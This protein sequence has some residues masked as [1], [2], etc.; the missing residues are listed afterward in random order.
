M[1]DNTNL[2][3]IEK[4]NTTE[5]MSFR[6]PG[7][8]LAEAKRAAV[9]LRNVITQKEKP[10]IFNNEQYLEYEDWQLLGQFCGGIKAKVTWTR[11]LDMGGGVKGFEA[12]ADAVDQDGNILSSA[13][14]MCLNDEDNWST[15]S[16]FEY[17][18]IAEAEAKGLPI[19]KRYDSGR[20]QVKVGDVPVPMFQLRSMAQTR[21]CAK[22]L[23]NCLRWVAVL[24]NFAPTPA[25][26]MTGYERNEP[27]PAKPTIKP[28][29]QVKPTEN[30]KPPAGQLRYI[31][32]IAT[33]NGVAA[34]TGKPWTRYDIYFEGDQKKYSTFSES[35]AATAED[36]ESKGLGVV[37]EIKATQSGK[38]TNYSIEHIE[39]VPN[40]VRP[41]SEPIE[42]T[43]DGKIP[44]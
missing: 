15:R 6:D 17:T 34:K 40:S 26:E 28:P 16:K 37:C 19:T 8:V 36:A 5:L 4:T 35:F 14:S 41:A 43:A 38:Y 1:N 20:C 42:A 21:A 32:G 24:A 27:Q 2:Q 12:G 9:A 13:E 33:E 29:Q 39:I 23:N 44:F 3:V 22:A 11:F 25:E 10:V 31:A 7:A 30:G 18:T